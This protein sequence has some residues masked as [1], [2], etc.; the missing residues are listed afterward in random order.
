[1]KTFYLNGFIGLDIDASV[2]QNIL[3]SALGEDITINLFTRGGSVYDA[4]EIHNLIKQYSA[5]K[6][7]YLGGLV[8]SAG[9][10]VSAAFDTVYAQDISIFMIHNAQAWTGGD[11]KQLKKDAEQLEQTNTHMANILAARANRP[12]EE[13]LK[14]MDETTWYYGSEI[15]EAGF[16]DELLATTNI[17]AKDPAITNAKKEFSNI[18][19]IVVDG[20]KKINTNKG[21]PM[22]KEQLLAALGAQGV[23]LLEAANALSAVNQILTPE[24]TKALEV[25]A[26]FKK[27]GIDDPVATL[28]DLK[29]KNDANTKIVRT[30]ALDTAFGKE[31]KLRMY[32]E[33][34]T[35][36][37]C[38]NW[39]T[40][41]ERIKKLPLAVTLAQE[42][43]DGNLN[44][45]SIIEQTNQAGKQTGVKVVE[46]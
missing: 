44:K 45:I 34:V 42:Q 29:A 35:A 41:I 11:F 39:E 9:S 16:A 25:M 8:A 2:V 28:S 26:S 21:V 3:Q 43:A 12:V 46:C 31:N 6:I 17:K 40:E 10:L 14:L 1:M 20:Y 30:A 38:D 18:L 36:Q 4:L 13:I 15:V 37:A 32:A 24:H 22:N 23:T 5:K 7:L 33:D 19:N 27:L